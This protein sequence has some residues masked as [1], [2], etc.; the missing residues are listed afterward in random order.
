[1]KHEQRVENQ[2]FES[3]GCNAVSVMV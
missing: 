2:K 1:M 3:F